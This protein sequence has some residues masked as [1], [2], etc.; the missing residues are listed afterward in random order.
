MRKKYFLVKSISNFDFFFCFLNNTVYT[1]I[2]Y[3]WLKQVFLLNTSFF[4]LDI[5][6]NSYVYNKKKFNSFII[7]KILNNLLFFWKFFWNFFVFQRSNL[8]GFFTELE[9]IGLGYRIKKINN[10]I[11]KFFCGF[12]NYF[13]LFTSSLI[14]IEYDIDKRLIFFFSNSASLVNGLVSQLLLLKKLSI[15]RINGILR[16]GKL[17]RLKSGK[18]R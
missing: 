5:F 11:Y 9:L 2:G 14:S 15:Y 17:I 8:I 6:H 13:Y 18:Q 12:S 1:R 7:F 4:Y 10:F 3:V 16:V